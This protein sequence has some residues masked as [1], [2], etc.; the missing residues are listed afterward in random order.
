MVTRRKKPLSPNEVGM[1]YGFRSGLEEKV[2]E[3]LTSNGVKFTFET[4]KVPYVKP[5][6]KHIYT[7]DFI[8]DNGI[9]IET[10]GRWLLDDRKKHIL[11]RKQRPDLDIRILFQNAN[12][13]ISKGSKT[14]YADFCEKHGIP[15]AHREIPVAWLKE[16]A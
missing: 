8:L 10:K 7:P 12:A 1:K 14:S 9:I 2:A 5:E 11:I 6:T 3:F 16:K 4:L 13:K 15:Y